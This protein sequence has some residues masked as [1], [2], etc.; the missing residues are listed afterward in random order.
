LDCCAEFRAL[1]ITTILLNYPDIQDR[2][3]AEIQENIGLDRLPTDLD[4][5]RIPYTRAI[6]TEGLRFRPPLWLGVPHSN[7]NDEEYEGYHIPAGSAHVINMY[8]LHF[9]P[10]RYPDPYSFKPERHLDTGNVRQHYAFGAG[11]RICPGSFLAEKSLFLSISRLIWAFRI[12]NALDAQGNKI[13]VPIIDEKLSST[14]LPR[15]KVRFVPRH[16][17]VLKLARFD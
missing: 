1:A 5:E 3:Y 7:P 6:L 13:E 10:E 15:F 16:D 4:E 17:N 14:V 8:G 11:R 12:E 9:N 2:A